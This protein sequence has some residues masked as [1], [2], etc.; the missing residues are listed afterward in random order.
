MSSPFTV[1]KVTNTMLTMSDIS[2]FLN[3][4]FI[5]WQ[6]KKGERKTLDDYASFIGV[7]RPLLSMWMSG[8][9]KPGTKNKKRLVELYGDEAVTALGEDPRLFFINEHWSDASEDLQRAV[10]EQVRKGI[11]KNDSDTRRISRRREKTSD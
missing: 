11:E 4:K 6:Y 3:S 9:K 10:Y 1:E 5:E 7:S 8:T 2:R